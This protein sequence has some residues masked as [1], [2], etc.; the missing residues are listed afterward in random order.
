[1]M[2]QPF[3]LL[4]GLLISGAIYGQE[5]GSKSY[6]LMLK[7]LL[8]HTVPETAVG[9]VDELNFVLLDA[10]EMGEYNVSRIKGAKWVGYEDF[11]LDRVEGINKKSKILVYCSVGYRSEKVA[12]RLIAAGFTDVSNLYG[13]IFEWVNQKNQVVDSSGNTVEKIHAYNKVW[14]LWLRRGEKV[15]E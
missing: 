9:E 8:S 11:T 14:G 7:T 1:M 5:V 13:G 12:E 15:Y 10:R 6:Q 3:V 4:I 2:R